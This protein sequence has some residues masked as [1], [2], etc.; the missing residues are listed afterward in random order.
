MR[1]PEGVKR[2]RQLRGL[3]RDEVAARSGMSHETVDSVERG[4]EVY[5]RTWRR[6]LDVLEAVPLSSVLGELE[7]RAS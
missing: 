3:T 2:L 5:P 4:E 1:A 6:Y 7:M